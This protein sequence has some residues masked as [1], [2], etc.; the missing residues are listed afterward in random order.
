MK[1][2]S[3]IIALS[4]LV[5]FFFSC[6]EESDVKKDMGEWDS[7][8][9]TEFAVTPIYG[10]ATI[11]YKI[12]NEQDILYI[13]AEYERNG[14]LFTEK[15]SIHL[16]EIILEGFHRQDLVKAKIYKVNKDNQK[17][18]PISIEF[19]PLE[20]VISLAQNSLELIPG[21]GGIVASW[22]NPM[23]ADLAISILLED[24]LD[25]TKLNLK[26]VYYS[27]MEKDFHPFR[28]YKS[29]ETTFA[30]FVEDI[31]GNV[32]DTIRFT[33]TPLFEMIIPKPYADFR[34][35]VPYDNITNYD[36]ARTFIRLWD[37][38]VNQSGH[39]W[40]TSSGNS[41]LS[42]TIDMKQVAKLSRM[43][44]HGYH[45]NA[46]WGQANASQWEIWGIDKFDNN[47]I[48]DKPY[49]LDE[50]SVRMGA[51][52]KGG[53]ESSAPIPA[54]TFKDDWTYLGLHTL[55]KLKDT[56][57]EF[58]NNVYKNGMEYI[59]P[60]NAK[61]VRYVRMFVREVTGLPPSSANYWSAGEIT[62]YGDNNVEQP[63]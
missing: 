57:A 33:T 16:N 13:M 46:M 44:I 22:D 12:P 60:A 40:L 63:K 29:V 8:P 26:D 5:F 3:F 39:G 50:E 18:A 36:A 10:G 4:L 34:G 37:N 47:K 9:I 6:Y 56:D 35:F 51:L 31:W 2:Y 17:S 55:P 49:W 23:K 42:M 1:K 59:M 24:S 19:E 41:G 52:V 53:V 58:Q 62:F 30:V 38:I 25:I 14:E 11:T 43:V 32:S 54:R 21:F 28:G 48:A 15:S 45:I 20:S 27:A 61:P 7:G